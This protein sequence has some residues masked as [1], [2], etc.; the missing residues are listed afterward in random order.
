MIK[1]TK[2]SCPTIRRRSKDFAYYICLFNFFNK[3]LQYYYKYIYLRGL[4]V[5][6]IRKDNFFTEDELRQQNEFLEFKRNNIDG[7][8]ITGFKFTGGYNLH[9]FIGFSLDEGCL[10][11]LKEK[12]IIDACAFTGDTSLP[13]S[14]LTR[15]NV[16]ALNHLMNLLT[17]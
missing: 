10:E 4:F 7:D 5:N 16:Y 17:C 14:K 11:F 1:R 15:A 12:D 3:K 9:P 13:L 2:I 6:F 8:Q